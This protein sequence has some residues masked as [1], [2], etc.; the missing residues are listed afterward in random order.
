MTGINPFL[1]LGLNVTVLG[2][3]S[4]ED[5]LQLAKSQY[6]ALSQIHHPDRGGDADLFALLSDAYESLQDSR[7]RQ[8]KLEE[9][10]TSRLDQLTLVQQEL[11]DLERQRRRD[12]R[13][14][15][16]HTADF[17]A[18]FV[19]SQHTETAQPLNVHDL[20]LVV[21]DRHSDFMSGALSTDAERNKAEFIEHYTTHGFKVVRR[22][23]GHV[24]VADLQVMQVMPSSDFTP[25]RFK[26][27]AAEFTHVG[28]RKKAPYPSYNSWYRVDLESTE[29]YENQLRQLEIEAEAEGR[30]LE[31]A[32]IDPTSALYCYEEQ[33]TEATDWALIGTLSDGLI[34]TD[35]RGDAA[36][37]AAMERMLESAA[38]PNLREEL[39]RGYSFERFQYYL[40][41]LEAE[42]SEDGY[43][44][45]ARLEDDQIRFMLV[46]KIVP[47][48]EL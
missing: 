6:R 26:Q 21:Q 39:E 3:L 16:R 48:Q 43:L 47:H 14:L 4:D 18:D 20:T 23:G 8:E 5:I 30:T 12:N 36:P 11:T 34:G 31:D 7:A 44:V 2:G 33:S 13:R 41:Q 40:D 46:G 19:R 32:P 35:A 38:V 22:V 1:V 9:Y 27:F 29:A 25:A 28:A 45:A 15:R 37:G 10:R 24:S 17:M 42:F